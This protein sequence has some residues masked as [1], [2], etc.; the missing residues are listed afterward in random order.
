MALGEPDETG[1]RRPVHVA[2]DEAVVSVDC[3][4]LLLALGQSP[5][6]S[7]LPNACEPKDCRASLRGFGDTLVFA[8]G[9]FAT[10]EGTV[11]AAIGSGRAAAENI[12]AALA[13]RVAAEQ[14]EDRELAGPEVVACS[15]FPVTPQ[16]KCSADTGGGAAQRASPRCGR[17]SS[18]STATTR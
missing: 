3:D 16:S 15:A 7:L 13:G 18:T 9:D 1:R 17:A 2:G 8:G 11:T 12:M 4:R 5:D 6:L 14:T 10:R